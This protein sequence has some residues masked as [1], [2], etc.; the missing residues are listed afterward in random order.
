MKERSYTKLSELPP[1]RSHDGVKNPWSVIKTIFDR[2]VKKEEDSKASGTGTDAVYTTQKKYWK[3]LIFIKGR[4]DVDPAVSTLDPKENERLAKKI[5]A[6]KA[7][8]VEEVAIDVWFI[9]Y[10]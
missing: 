5:K 8:N 9:V 2:K 1:G 6:E 3:S 7:K 10:F 4:E